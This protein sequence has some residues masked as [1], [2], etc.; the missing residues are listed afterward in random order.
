MQS[1]LGGLP[2]GFP[3][4]I[5]LK[6]C[7]TNFLVMNKTGT[8]NEGFPPLMARVRPFSSVYFLMPMLQINIKPFCIVK[9]LL[10]NNMKASSE[11]FPTQS[12]LIRPFPHE[13]SL[14]LNQ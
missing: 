7:V 6:L 11:S 4:I 2:E 8:V 1:K 14:V 9:Y 3:T 10:P 12:T 13:N 5:A